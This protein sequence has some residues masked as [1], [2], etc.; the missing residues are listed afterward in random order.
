MNTCKKIKQQVYELSDATPIL[1]VVPNFLHKMYKDFG[2]VHLLH[3]HNKKNFKKMWGEQSCTWTG[4]ERE[5]IWLHEFEHCNLFVLTAANH[6][7]TY[8]VSPTRPSKEALKE[9]ED[10][11]RKTLEELRELKEENEQESKI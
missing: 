6:G 11:M 5:W 8:E 7:T 10:F 3:N 1:N 2:T 9:V 4:W